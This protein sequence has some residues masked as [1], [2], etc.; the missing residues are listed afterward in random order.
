MKQRLTQGEEGDEK[1]V[2]AKVYA[3]GFHFA[4]EMQ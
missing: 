4:A 3:R 1:S 2:K